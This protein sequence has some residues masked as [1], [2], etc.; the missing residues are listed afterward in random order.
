MHLIMHCTIS[1]IIE[2][3]QFIVTLCI[4]NLV[5]IIYNKIECITMHI[6]N[7][8]NALYPLITLYN[9]LCIKSLSEVLL[10]LFIRPLVHQEYQIY[11]C[12][13]SYCSGALHYTPYCT[14]LAGFEISV[15]NTISSITNLKGYDYILS[16]CKLLP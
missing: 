14:L 8:Y 9:A 10:L 6:M 1:L 3:Y 5:I 16:L 15:R 11:F 7:N 2:I 4:L 12:Y 13:S